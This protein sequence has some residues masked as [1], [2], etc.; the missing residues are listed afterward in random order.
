MPIISYLTQLTIVNYYSPIY[1][2]HAHRCELSMNHL[3]CELWTVLFS[4]EYAE[5]SCRFNTI[6]VY[7]YALCRHSLCIFRRLLNSPVCIISQSYSWGDC[8]FRCFIKWCIRLERSPA[9]QDAEQTKKNLSNFF[10]SL[11]LV[12]INSLQIY[13][14]KSENN[15]S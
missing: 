9:I 2:R 10:W 5:D 11:N 13:R 14:E 3:D 7:V 15:I 8:L 4:F 12:P 6:V 1:A